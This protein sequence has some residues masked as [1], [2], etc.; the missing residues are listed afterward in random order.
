[1]HKQTH[2]LYTTQQTTKKRSN[3]H[4]T[5]AHVSDWLCFV[6]FEA[7]QTQ[8]VS[9]IIRASAD[10]RS[11]VAALCKYSQY[12]T[13]AEP[14]IVLRIGEG[15]RYPYQGRLGLSVGPV[16]DHF[17]V[18]HILNM[19]ICIYIRICM[20]RMY[21]CVSVSFMFSKGEPV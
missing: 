11:S 6:K 1:M 2:T 12:R 10:M 15:T 8:T 20:M 21:A 14:G 16:T 9:A 17:S 13:A 3:K 4:T 5:I 18:C 7:H 19:Q